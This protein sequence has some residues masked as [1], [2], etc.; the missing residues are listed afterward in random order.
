MRPCRAFRRTYTVM[1]MTVP[2]GGS[3]LIRQ[4]YEFWTENDKSLKNSPMPQTPNVRIDR[5]SQSQKTP[6]RHKSHSDSQSFTKQSKTKTIACMIVYDILSIITWSASMRQR[7]RAFRRTYTA[8][9]LSLNYFG[10]RIL[11]RA[12][13][14]QYSQDVLVSQHC[15]QYRASQSGHMIGFLKTIIVKLVSPVRAMRNQQGSQVIINS[16]SSISNHGTAVP[17]VPGASDAS[18]ILEQ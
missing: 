4:L 11:S 15:W 2:K 9:G 3:G 14:S 12:R 10:R 8:P 1:P 16:S 13:D 5:I 7:C 17:P 6:T 18:D